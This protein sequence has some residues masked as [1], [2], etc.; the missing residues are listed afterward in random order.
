M[1]SA[2]LNPSERTVVSAGGSSRI[3]ML[4]GVLPL[5]MDGAGGGTSSI[6]PLRTMFKASMPAE[7]SHGTHP[8]NQDSFSSQPTTTATFADQPRPNVEDEG[9][10]DADDGLRDPAFVAAGGSPKLSPFDV[11]NS[12]VMDIVAI[13]MLLSYVYATITVGVANTYSL[14]AVFL[15]RL[16]LV[17][18]GPVLVS[19][20]LVVCICY[21]GLLG[22]VSRPKKYFKAAQK[23]TSPSNGNSTAEEPPQRDVLSGPGPNEL[24]HSSSEDDNKE[25]GIDGGGDEDENI[26]RL[27]LLPHH[28]KDSLFHRIVLRLRRRLQR[29]QRQRTSR[30]SP[31]SGQ[32]RPKLLV[33]MSCWKTQVIAKAKQGLF[34][35]LCWATVS[36]AHRSTTADP[37]H[38]HI[39]EATMRPSLRRWVSEEWRGYLVQ[40]AALLRKSSVAGSMSQEDHHADVSRSREDLCD[41]IRESSSSASASSRSVVLAA[42]TLAYVDLVHKWDVGSGPIGALSSTTFTKPSQ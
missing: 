2:L 34:D 22:L 15:L 38:L 4:G 36:E 27:R 29:A 23:G 6:H 30:F 31:R 12:L 26:I 21:F 19:Y 20:G 32:H 42:A 5:C 33:Q 3:T 41:T 8:I 37:A 14:W 40:G 35:A 39:T 18:A 28:D 11:S 9:D 1:M 16:I 7:E 25:L 13:Q 17:L 10:T 24:F